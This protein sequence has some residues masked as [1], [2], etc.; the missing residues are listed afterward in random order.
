MKI[1]I[2]SLSFHASD[3]LTDFTLDKVSKLKQYTERI[4]HAEVV[5][6]TDKSETKDNKVCEIRLAIPGSDLF[7]SKR[8]STFEDAVLRTVDA[9]KQQLISWKERTQNNSDNQ[10]TERI[11]SGN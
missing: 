7:A 10:T 4:M 9:L 6:K 5:L 1:N 2:Q 3:K 8:Q 11:E